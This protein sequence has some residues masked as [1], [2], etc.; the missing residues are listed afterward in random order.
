MG[1]ILLL[2]SST[3]VCSVALAKDGSLLDLEE[4]QE[5]LS[6]AE[7]LTSY[8][9]II[10]KRNNLKAKDID[11]FGV[12]KGPGSYTGLRIG[13]SAAKGLCYASKKNLIAVSTFDAMVWYILQN[14]HEFNI[15]PDGNMLLCP[16][17]DARRM[18]V[19]FAIYNTNLECVEPVS[20]KI[21]TENSFNELFEKNRIV[22]FGNGA[23]KCR[24][25]IKHPGAFFIGP[26]KVS[27]R[28]MVA[29]AEQKYTH[30]DFEDIAY[31]EPYYLKDFIATIPKNK[32]F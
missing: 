4:N 26:Q 23:E 24:N 12:S 31:F 21:I 27:A 1:L 29:L 13:I 6:H 22:F 30:K 8:V 18:E 11:A 20:A 15:N 9:E 2:E 7:L 28:F 10:L 19:Y 16:M 32:F 3:E 25:V 5:G 14:Q 17:I